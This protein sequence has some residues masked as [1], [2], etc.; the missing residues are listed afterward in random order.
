MSPGMGSTNMNQIPGMSTL[1][2]PEGNLMLSPQQ[3]LL[4]MEQMRRQGGIP[5]QAPSFNPGVR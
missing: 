3:K 1:G 2:E 5:G 4:M